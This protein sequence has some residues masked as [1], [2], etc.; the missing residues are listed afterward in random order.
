LKEKEIKV[1]HVQFDLCQI[2]IIGIL[3][4]ICFYPIALT[5]MAAAVP[6]CNGE[7]RREISNPASSKH[8]RSSS[9]SSGSSTYSTPDSLPLADTIASFFSTI[10]KAGYPDPE[11]ISQKDQ[12]WK[13]GWSGPSLPAADGSLLVACNQNMDYGSGSGL[14]GY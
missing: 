1:N 3:Q 5:H 10:S 8:S 7:E 6:S 4:F 9:F 14:G 2:E 12:P 13:K 11:A